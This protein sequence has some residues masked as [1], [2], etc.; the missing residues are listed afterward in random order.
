MFR[1]AVTKYVV[2]GPIAVTHTVNDWA[3]RFLFP[4]GAIIPFAKQK[5]KEARFGAVGANGVVG[6]ESEYAPPLQEL[7]AMPAKVNL[8]KGRFNNLQVKDKKVLGGHNLVWNVNIANLLVQ[9]MQS[10]KTTV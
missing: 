7:K 5:Q 6:L 9:V 3:L 10:T 2:S 4:P 8:T 1:L